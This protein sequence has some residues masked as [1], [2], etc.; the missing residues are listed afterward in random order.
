MQFEQ[1]LQHI[2]QQIDAGELASAETALRQILQQQPRNGFALYLMGM[3]AHRTGHAAFR[4][5]LGRDHH[6]QSS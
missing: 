2:A 4:N 3:L 1:L 6:S 5:Y